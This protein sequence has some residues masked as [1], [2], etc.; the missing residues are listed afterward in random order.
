MARGLL[1]Q[2]REIFDGDPGVKFLQARTLAETRW[3]QLAVN[4]PAPRID[5]EGRFSAL[6]TNQFRRAPDGAW[7]YGLYSELFTLP[8]SVLL[9]FFGIR[10][11]YLVPV[12]ACMGTMIVAYRLAA[13]L[14]H[15]VASP[16]R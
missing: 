1:A 7:Y 3:G 5:P 6:A 9:A 15:G 16:A 12:L 11:I 2:I 14:A 13:R 8:T 10:A 4:N